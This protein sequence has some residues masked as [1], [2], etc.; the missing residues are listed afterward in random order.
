M[1]PFQY[2]EL[3]TPVKYRGDINMNEIKSDKISIHTIMFVRFIPFITKKSLMHYILYCFCPVSAG[4]LFEKKNVCNVQSMIFKRTHSCLNN[5]KPSK[6]TAVQLTG[7]Y[8]QFHFDSC[9][10]WNSLLFFCR[11][12]LLCICLK[13]RTCLFPSL[14]FGLNS[15]AHPSYPDTSC[16]GT[17]MEGRRW[18]SHSPQFLN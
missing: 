4:L 10:H 12:F 8:M 13:T 6:K 14:L 11:Q 17:W 9:S 7:Y 16:L 1:S 2:G 15:H 5:V 3:F 18:Y